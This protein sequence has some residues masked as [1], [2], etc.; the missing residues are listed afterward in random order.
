[1]SEEDLNK[2]QKA[3]C[4]SQYL[5]MNLSNL[6]AAKIVAERQIRPQLESDAYSGLSSNSA[7]FSPTL[8]EAEMQTTPQTDCVQQQ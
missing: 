3:G 1:M 8:K 4:A 6:D 7:I 5:S 2:F